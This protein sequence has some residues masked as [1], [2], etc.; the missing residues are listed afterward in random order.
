MVFGTSVVFLL[1]KDAVFVSATRPGHVDEHLPGAPL[2]H[3]KD[4]TA[5][6]TAEEEEEE[7]YLAAHHAHA[8][9]TGH[10]VPAVPAVT[11]G[12][13]SEQLD[14][15]MPLPKKKFEHI[16][17]PLG[18]DATL[19]EEKPLLEQERE[20]FEHV[21][22]HLGHN[23]AT[24]DEDRRATHHASGGLHNSGLH[25]HRLQGHGKA[26]G[27]GTKAADIIDIPADE[28]KVTEDIKV[29]KKAEVVLKK[30][31]DDF[32]AEEDMG[33]DGIKPTTLGEDRRTTHHTSGGEREDALLNSRARLGR[34][35]TV[36]KGDIEAMEG[37]AGDLAKLIPGLAPLE[38]D[39]QEVAEK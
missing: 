37:V 26:R 27:G 39:L 14:E 5:D 16:A 33:V 29:V 10:S 9:P 21:A 18:H 23:A 2:R 36:V 3:L 32:Q 28:K 31:F 30:V 22:T 6:V 8:R 1:L 19:D 25:S 12:E 4:V 38:I 24:L 11:P 34:T 17:P 7:Q 35:N 20:E 15:E 13:E